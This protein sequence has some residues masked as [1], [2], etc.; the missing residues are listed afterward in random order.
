MVERSPR[1][2]AS[3]E[4]ATT[5]NQTNTGAVS[6]ATLAKLLRWVGAH[7]GFLKLHMCEDTNLN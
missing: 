2:L 3:E 5:T 6:K 7:M 1:I 4:K